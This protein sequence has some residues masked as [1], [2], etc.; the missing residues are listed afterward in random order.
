MIAVARTARRVVLTIGTE[1]HELWPA[2]ARLVA[3][4]LR[5]GHN[6]RFELAA[7]D[8]L[9]LRERIELARAL[10]AHA[11]EIVRCNDPRQTLLFAR[12]LR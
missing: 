12:G 3:T 7:L 2:R 4:E 1:R 9:D 8:R 6:R 10:D 5:Q 11:D